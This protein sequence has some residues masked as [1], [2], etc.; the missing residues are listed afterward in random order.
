MKGKKERILVVFWSSESDREGNL[1]NAVDKQLP[2][3]IKI[4]TGKSEKTQPL[5]IKF[6]S[7]VMQKKTF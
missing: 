2:D 7:E 6:G 3:T 4:K 5:K 1:L